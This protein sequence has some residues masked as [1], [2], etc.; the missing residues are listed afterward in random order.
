VPE[1]RTSLTSPGGISSSLP[2]MA[3]VRQVDESRVRSIV[4]AAVSFGLILCVVAMVI[5]LRMALHATVVACP[6]G[7]YFPAGTTD[8]RCFAHKHAGDGTSIVIFAVIFAIVLSLGGLIAQM[9]LRRQ[10][11]R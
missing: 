1:D 10:G 6:D 5:G 2:R 4:G 9:E 7:H 11:S 3:D 8:F